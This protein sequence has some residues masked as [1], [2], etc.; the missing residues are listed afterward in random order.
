MIPIDYHSDQTVLRSR[1]THR[2]GE[3]VSLAEGEIRSRPR[4]K[5]ERRSEDALVSVNDGRAKAVMK[6]M[7]NDLS[8][9][10]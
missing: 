10:T 4:G 3:V 2:C 9:I 8:G 7:H 6:I 1:D 5:R